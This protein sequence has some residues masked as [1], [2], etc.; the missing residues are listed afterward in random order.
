MGEGGGGHGV[1]LRGGVQW[2]D[3]VLV[4]LSP[5]FLS[6]SRLFFSLFYFY[7]SHFFLLLGVP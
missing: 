7:F 2:F 3:C 5:P 1:R 4:R 6:L